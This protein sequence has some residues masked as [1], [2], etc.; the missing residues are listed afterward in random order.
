MNALRLLK[1][2]QAQHERELLGV[3]VHTVHAAISRS[4]LT[5]ALAPS[6]QGRRKQRFAQRVFD[7]RAP[8]SSL[9]ETRD[10]QRRS[11]DLRVSH[12]K[13][14]GVVIND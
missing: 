13:P 8:T 1:Q 3:K 12:V 10:G 7:V 9:R 6:S 5:T 4:E 14:R 11:D 2:W